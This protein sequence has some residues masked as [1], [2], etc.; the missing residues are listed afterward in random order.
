MVQVVDCFPGGG[1]RSNEDVFKRLRNEGFHVE[2]SLSYYPFVCAYDCESY[3]EAPAP[4]DPTQ[5]AGKT[6][7]LGKHVLAS[8]GI[9]SNVPG[10]TN[11][12]GDPKPIVLVS[13]GNPMELT[14]TFLGVLESLSDVAV[15]KLT[16]KYQHIFDELSMEEQSFSFLK[17]QFEQQYQPL[18]SPRRS[19]GVDNWA[20]VPQLVQAEYLYV[21]QKLYRIQGLSKDLRS[22]IAEMPTLGF[23]SSR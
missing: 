12:A 5:A 20:G 19:R 3:I 22:W 23:N 4:Q 17:D 15:A 10:H 6:Q 11:E 9:A 14:K 16:P 8:V 18:L 13:E 7:I 2:E 21:S 1:Y